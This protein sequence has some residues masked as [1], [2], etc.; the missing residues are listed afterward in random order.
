MNKGVRLASC[1]AL[2]LVLV[3]AGVQADEQS[4]GHRALAMKYVQGG[5][6][7]DAEREYRLALETADAAGKPELQYR[8][9]YCLHRQ[10]KLQPAIDEYRKVLVMEGA[11]GPLRGRAQLGIGQCFQ[12]EGKYA[13][14]QAAYAAVEGIDGAEPDRLA[15]AHLSSG[16]TYGKMEKDQESIAAY[17]S[18]MDV[19]GANPVTYQTALVSAGGRYQEGAKYSEAVD[20]YKRAI[21]IGGGS[22]AE[23]AENRLKECQA[24]LKG[25]REFFIE[26]YVTDASD[27]AA[28]VC[29]VSREGVS[30]GTV[31]A[32]GAG[33]HVKA[34]AT[35]QKIRDRDMV[36]QTA[37]LKGLQPYTR[38]AYTAACD[39]NQAEGS[40]RTARREPGPVRF[41]AYGD[42]QTGWQYHEKL[43]ALMAAEDPD[44]VV[45][46]GDCV[47]QGNRWDEWKVQMFD[48]ARAFLK[49]CPIYVSWGNHDATPYFMDLFGYLERPFKHVL[50]GD[51][52]VYLLDSNFHFGKT[53]CEEQLAWFEKTL[54]S[55]KALWKVVA[56]HHPMY[57]TVPGD[58]LAGLGTFRPVIETNGVD[59]V[60]NGHYH[61]YTRL[62][63]IGVPG[64]KPV[65]NIITGGGGGRQGTVPCLSPISVVDLCVKHYTLFEI[66]GD[67]LTMTA[68]DIHGQVIDH[69]DLVKKDGMY[70]PAVMAATVD[71]DLSQQI[72]MVYNDLKHQHYNRDDLTGSYTQSDGEG[73]VQLDW[74][75]LDVTTLPD[76][77]ELVVRGS[78]GCNWDVPA[79]TIALSSDALR[80]RATPPTDTTSKATLK[81]NPLEIVLTLKIGDRFFVPQQF[82]VS[83]A[84]VE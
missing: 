13:E 53:T 16:H 68:K 52:E 46:V 43:A 78:A 66:D 81:E 75:I 50:S 55:S 11:D 70:Q 64:R 57:H 31:S 62:L 19:K 28:T 23:V 71:S 56:F 8:V 54:A 84:D 15:Q 30:A 44:F 27:T 22:Y 49:Q 3:G 37:V 14:A 67:H 82:P 34:T 63:P 48:P 12:L 47:E 58:R 29:W 65:V 25:S 36:L 72:R 32:T 24:A 35:V 61:V 6:Y 2:A 40:F 38:Y 33:D 39:G 41:I 9:A 45:H 76:G 60:L 79:Q 20:C 26:P 21:L 10:Y 4:D 77:S 51:V 7:A 73:M 17:L 80:F 42:T 74:N 5:R 18:V 59:F 69:L 83:L 1:I